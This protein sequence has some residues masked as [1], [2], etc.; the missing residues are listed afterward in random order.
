MNTT[1]GDL[2]LDLTEAEDTEIQVSSVSGDIDLRLPG[3]V[4]EIA[5]ALRSVSGDIRCRGVDIVEEA[6]VRVNANTVSGDL[7]IH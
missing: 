4:R 1:S 2:S 3:K 5:A 6:S 7:R